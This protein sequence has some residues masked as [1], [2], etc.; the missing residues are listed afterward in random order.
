MAQ[1]QDL[2]LEN[3]STVQ[4][5]VFP[6]LGLIIIN[7]LQDFAENWIEII[8][9]RESQF[10]MDLSIRTLSG[11][12]EHGAV[13]GVCRYFIETLL[14]TSKE[15]FNFEAEKLGHS[16]KFIVNINLK[17]DILNDRSQ[18]KTVGEALVSLFNW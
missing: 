7:D 1:T 5:G 6:K 8:V 17:Q 12:G 4:L 11:H 14:K 18:I 9:T 13:E 16:M 2:I 15:T 3:K 10:K